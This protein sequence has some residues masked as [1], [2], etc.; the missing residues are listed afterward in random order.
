MSELASRVVAVKTDH[1]ST[2]QGIS[3]VNTMVIIGVVSEGLGALGMGFD[4]DEGGNFMRH[5]ERE[6]RMGGG[7]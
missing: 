7:P 6:E 3:F 1:V 2:R 5:K 4:V